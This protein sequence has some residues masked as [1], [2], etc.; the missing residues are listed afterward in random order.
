MNFLNFFGRKKEAIVSEQPPG[1]GTSPL[2]QTTE[3]YAK[4]RQEKTPVGKSIFP[5]VRSA[6][7]PRF[8]NNS[9]S[10]FITGELAE[11]IVMVYGLDIGDN[12]EIIS[13][14]HCERFH[15]G[16]E[17]LFHLAKR[18]LLNK[19]SGNIDI[20]QVDF[21]ENTQ[22]AQPFYRAA[23]DNNLDTSLMLVDE[24]WEHVSNML[25]TNL[26]A[27]NLPAKNLLYF[28]SLEQMLSF[29][30]MRH[31]S[32]KMFDVSKKDGI[33]ITPDTYIRKNGK[34]VLFS[35]EY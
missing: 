16:K 28:A 31:V 1:A 27:V 17:E 9:I 32:G 10:G 13:E 24:F 26:I 2:E 3:A 22:G 5:L 6:K 15:I 11:G 30:T 14:N 34:W 7:D 20:E 19:T 33:E 21:S 18:N 35:N 25:K 8:S 23:L 29:R 4:E 12:F